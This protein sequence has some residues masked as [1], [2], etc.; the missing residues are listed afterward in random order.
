MTRSTTS[1]E[2]NF[3]REFEA[4]IARNLEDALEREEQFSRGFER[5]FQ[6]NYQ[7]TMKQV[8]TIGGGSGQSN[9]LNGLSYFRDEIDISSIVSTTDSGGST[10]ILREELGILAVGDIRRCLVA[11]S[12]AP[13][14][15]KELMDYRFDRG[16]L[17]GHNLGNLILA[18][19]MGIMRDDATAIEEA[20]KLLQINGR[21]LPVTTDK[22]DLVAVLEDGSLIKGETDIDVPKYDLKQLGKSIKQVYLEPS[23]VAHP[24]SLEAI[25]NADYIIIG[26]GDLY[27]SVIPNFLPEGVPEAIKDSKAQKIYVCNLMTKNGETDGYEAIDF[28]QA[29]ERYLGQNIIDHVIVNSGKIKPEKL[30]RYQNKGQH[31]VAYDVD[32]VRMHGKGINIVETN[33]V[34]GH[35]LVRHE[36]VKLANQIMSIVRYIPEAEMEV[37][38]M[39]G[40]LAFNIL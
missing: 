4:Q 18:G 30:M 16:S 5:Q 1:F 9:L 32:Q 40:T 12:D 17:D 11:L 37:P 14:S 22:S 35:D 6:E 38:A 31:P 19:L 10:G 21:V 23:A 34:N 36:P 29:I 15:M 20:G 24:E 2:E 8:V 33:L 26:P 13:E 28:V 3:R 25:S 27:T 7:S 39:A